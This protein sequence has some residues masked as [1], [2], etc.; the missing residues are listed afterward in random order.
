[1]WCSATACLI[2][3]EPCSCRCCFKPIVIDAVTARLIQS[4]LT[5]M[6]MQNHAELKLGRLPRHEQKENSVICSV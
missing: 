5:G 4:Q 1:M 3:H 6:S 2:L